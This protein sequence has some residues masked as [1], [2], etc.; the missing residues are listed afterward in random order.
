MITQDSITITSSLT[1]TTSKWLVVGDA[2]RILSSHDDRASA[3]ACMAD[4]EM[5]PELGCS[6]IKA[7]APGEAWTAVGVAPRPMTA[8]E[9]QANSGSLLDYLTSSLAAR[10]VT[11]R[12][13]SNE[14]N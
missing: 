8:S 13:H 6:E 2:R 7:L 4:P 14:R 1:N 11:Q 5:H 3:I 10:T 12:S 9:E